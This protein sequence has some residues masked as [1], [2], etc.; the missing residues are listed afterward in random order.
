MRRYFG[1]N[2][3]GD[4]RWG[5]PW[6]FGVRGGWK[7]IVRASIRCNITIIGGNTEA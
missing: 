1:M 2:W 5:N 4:M 6:M 7:G 3:E